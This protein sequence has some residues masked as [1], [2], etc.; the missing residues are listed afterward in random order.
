MSKYLDTEGLKRVWNKIKEKCLLVSGGTMTGDITFSQTGKLQAIKSAFGQTII[1]FDG[2]QG[3]N[4]GELQMGANDMDIVMTSNYKPEVSCYNNGYA[5]GDYVML[6]SEFKVLTQDEY[7][8]LSTK[9]N[10]TFYFIK[11]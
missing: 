9:K 6:Q 3:S 8:G 2:S 5:S 4:A 10:G 11:E 7:D 1:G